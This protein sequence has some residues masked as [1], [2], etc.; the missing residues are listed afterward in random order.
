M[1]TDFS[2]MSGVAQKESNF[3]NLYIMPF[4]MRS[5]GIRFGAVRSHAVLSRE[6]CLTARLKKARGAR[7]WQCNGSSAAIRLQLLSTAT[8]M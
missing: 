2:F 8:D 1:N 3:G 6:P 5:S 4:C 7:V